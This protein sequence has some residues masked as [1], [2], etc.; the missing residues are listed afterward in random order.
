MDDHAAQISADI[1]P[2]TDAPE[3]GAEE[4]KSGAA[5][6]GAG[7]GGGGAASETAYEKR[8]RLLRGPAPARDPMMDPV[9]VILRVTDVQVRSGTR[10]CALLT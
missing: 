8:A 9:N 7:G 3:G 4:T 10:S 5:E 6:G 1:A 2:F